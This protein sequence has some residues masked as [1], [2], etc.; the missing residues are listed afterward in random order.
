L[1]KVSRDRW[2]AFWASPPARQVDLQADLGRLERWIQAVDEYERTAK[3]VRRVRIVKGSMGQMV[4]N[5]LVSYLALLEGQIA[6]AEADFGM[7]PAA[8]KRLAITALPQQ[9]EED[10]V[11][12]LRAR[13]AARRAQSAG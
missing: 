7:S 8:R 4:L 12:Q 9:S 1:L 10:P 11:D 5:P 2:R 6:R 3:V 13:R